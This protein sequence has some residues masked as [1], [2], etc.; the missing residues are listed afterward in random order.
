LQADHPHLKGAENLDWLLRKLEDEKVEL[1]DCN[2]W[3]NLAVTSVKVHEVQGEDK[4]LRNLLGVFASE[5]KKV[6]AKF[7]E[8]HNHCSS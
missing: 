2:G 7:P 8:L 3:V 6:Y 4:K 1:V 5:F